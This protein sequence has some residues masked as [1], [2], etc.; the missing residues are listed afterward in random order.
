MTCRHS[1][2]FIFLLVAILTLMVSSVWSVELNGRVVSVTGKAVTIKLEGNLN[3]QIGD[4]VA[5][6]EPIPGLGTLPLEG[7]WKVST[8]NPKTI[9]AEPVGQAS[10]PQEGQ[11]VVVQS[12]QPSSGAPSQADVKETYQRGLNYLKGEQGVEKDVTKGVSLIRN[13][14]S[15]GNSLAQGQLG[16][17]YSHGIGVVAD[18]KESFQWSRK[19]AMQG[20]IVSQYNVAADFYKGRGIAEDKTEATKWFRKAANQGH[21]G[22]QASM[23]RAYYKGYGVSQDYAEAAMWYEKAAQRGDAFSQRRLGLMYAQGEGVPQSSSIAYDWYK[24]AAGQ[25]DVLSQ[26]Q[27]GFMYW[28]GKGVPKDKVKSFYW[29]RKAARQGE[30]GAQSLTAMCYQRGTG[31]AKDID[32]AI[33]WYQKAAAQGDEDAKEELATLNATSGSGLQGSASSAGRPHSGPI[34]AGASQ[35]I[36]QIQSTDGA[37]QQRGAKL[38]ARSAYKSDPAVLA[39]VADELL[40]GCTLNPRDKRHVDAMAWLCKILG[41]SGDKAYQPTLQ[42]VSK[43]TRSRKIKKFARKYAASLR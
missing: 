25:D 1:L 13:A 35:I 23:G 41:T 40:K 32:K 10:Q 3:P 14:A 26:K 27:L 7:E 42:K 6:H 18:D 43:T 33:Y 17:L 36:S 28:N 19:A 31:T 39:V 5:I 8:I 24:K 9:I 22:A 2:R 4:P 38:L 37:S 20:H 11:I 34:P 21:L 29:F 16:Y 12:A 15:Q 30:V